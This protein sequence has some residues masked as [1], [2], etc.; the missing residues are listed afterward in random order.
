ML[1]V[2]SLASW[3]AHITDAPNPTADLNSAENGPNSDRVSP[4]GPLLA[5]TRPVQPEA[6]NDASAVNLVGTLNHGHDEEDV[7]WRTEDGR[8][9]TPAVDFA[10]PSTQETTPG[11]GEQGEDKSP[12]ITAG[13]EDEESRHGEI[14]WDATER[15]TLE[16]AN[17][18]RVIDLMNRQA[19]R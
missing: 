12:S 16:P 8:S 4:N 5:A 11:P 19:R 14:N 3:A 18:R 7:L 13:D 1:V 9:P 2:H 10:S 17:A 6:L 15:E